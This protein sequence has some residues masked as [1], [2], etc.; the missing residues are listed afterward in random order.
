MSIVILLAIASGTVPMPGDVGDRRSW[1]TSDDYPNDEFRAG[2]NGSIYFKTI[3]NPSGRAE[4]CIIEM[5]TLGGRDKAAFC[6]VVKSR[7]KYRNV[8]GPDGSP[9]YFIEEK[10]FFYQVPGSKIGTQMRPGPDFAVEVQALPKT[11]KGRVEVL[12]NVAVDEAGQLKKCDA[13]AEAAHP[14]LARLACGQFP[15]LWA[16]MP[17]KNATGEPIAYIRQMRVEFREA[18]APAS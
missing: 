5:S 10:S 6:A 15:S 9:M 11:L 14:T 17:E 18:G 7:F 13:P 16:A 3:A 4:V 12:V 1:L 8:T 2:R